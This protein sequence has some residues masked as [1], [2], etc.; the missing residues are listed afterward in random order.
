M[1]GTPDMLFDANLYAAMNTFGE[2]ADEKAPQAPPAAPA[3]VIPERIN[4][5]DTRVPAS[6]PVPASRQLV[7]PAAPA[8]P[9]VSAPPLRPIPE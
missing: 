5:P 1:R 9:P 6:R 4:S 3:S 2:K 7:R 8:A